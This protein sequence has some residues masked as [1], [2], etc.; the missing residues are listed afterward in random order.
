MEL[1]YPEIWLG[2][3]RAGQLGSVGSF[4]MSHE[5]P[6]ASL[7]CTLDRTNNR[8]RSPRL[9]ASGQLEESR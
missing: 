6:R 2:V 4:V 3:G 9:A 5:N 8:I 7:K 1:D